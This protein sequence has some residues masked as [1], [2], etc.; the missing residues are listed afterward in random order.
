MYTYLYIGVYKEGHDLM[1]KRERYC[2]LPLR[3]ISQVYSQYTPRYTNLYKCS[4]YSLYIYSY[5]HMLRIYITLPLHLCYILYTIY[6]YTIHTHIKHSLHMYICY[7]Q[8]T[9][10]STTDKYLYIMY[11]CIY[12]ILL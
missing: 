10:V 9:Y 7:P 5:N 11:I 6:V 12:S 2:A 1:L 8:Y 3:Y 4:V